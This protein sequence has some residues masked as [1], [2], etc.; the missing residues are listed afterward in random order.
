MFRRICND[1]TVAANLARHFHSAG[2]QDVTTQTSVA[3]T[4]SLDTHPFWSSFLIGQLPMFVHA[5]V[6]DAS[7]AEA[8]AKDL[9]HLSSRGMFH[10]SFIIR[11]AVGTKPG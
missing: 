4:D 11:T 7:I 5:E 1:Y 2:L 10:A 9:E 6:L 3:H 8:L